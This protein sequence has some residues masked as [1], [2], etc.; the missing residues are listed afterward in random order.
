MERDHINTQFCFV[1]VESNH[2]SVNF[3]I[4]SNWR[5]FF[6]FFS[7]ADIFFFLDLPFQTRLLSTLGYKNVGFTA[8]VVL[9]VATFHGDLSNRDYG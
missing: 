5:E 1:D 9:Y 6:F 3:D 4:L 8:T 2:F 7:C